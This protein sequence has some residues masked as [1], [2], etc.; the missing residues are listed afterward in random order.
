MTG[1]VTGD[2]DRAFLDLV[3]QVGALARSLMAAQGDIAALEA[4]VAHHE[5]TVAALEHEINAAGVRH[6]NELRNLEGRIYD[7]E[8]QLRSIR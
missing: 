2:G 8:A 1:E 3:A 7:L 5:A 4:H 6:S